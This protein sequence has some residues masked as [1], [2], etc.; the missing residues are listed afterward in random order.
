ME[1]R[2]KRS[3]MLFE[4]RRCLEKASGGQGSRCMSHLDCSRSGNF[5]TKRRLRYGFSPRAIE[6]DCRAYSWDPGQ[7]VG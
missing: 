4:S 3:A 1:H 5:S 7:I 2:L 6:R